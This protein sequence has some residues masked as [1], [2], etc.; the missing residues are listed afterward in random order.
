VSRFTQSFSEHRVQ[1]SSAA[2]FILR[3]LAF[4]LALACSRFGIRRPARISRRFEP[5]VIVMASIS[6]SVLEPPFCQ[7]AK[8]SV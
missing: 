7:S 5:G 6:V 1:R 4:I 2:R 3:I 8:L